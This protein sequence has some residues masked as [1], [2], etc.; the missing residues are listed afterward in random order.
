MATATCY[1]HRPPCASQNVVFVVDTCFQFFL[2]YK[3]PLKHGGGTVKAHKKIAMHYLETW[4]FVP[5]T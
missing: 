5:L 1:G 3:K 4:L 2:P